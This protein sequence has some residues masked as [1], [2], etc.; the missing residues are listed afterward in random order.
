MLV[1]FIVFSALVFSG[2]E[3]KPLPLQVCSADVERAIKL[4]NEGI[5]LAHQSET[6]RVRI[7]LEKL[8][9]ALDCDPNNPEILFN[10][11]QLYL[12]FRPEVKAMHN[13]NDKQLFQRVEDY[14]RRAAEIGG[15]YQFWYDYAV[16]LLYGYKNLGIALDSEIAA[17]AWRKVRELSS[18]QDQVFN[19]WINEGRS[20]L[21]SLNKKQAQA[22]FEEALKIK[23]ESVI[24]TSLLEKVKSSN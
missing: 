17:G 11:S 20:R 23:P 3:V 2:V 18:T 4:N 15:T 24:A 12:I 9:M 7:G 1:S 19:S 5:K 16:N 14:S 22:C 10:I 8:E 21:W 13:W 6:N